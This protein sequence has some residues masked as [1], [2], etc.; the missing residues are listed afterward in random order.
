MMAA[1]ACWEV[2]VIVNVFIVVCDRCV[3]RTKMARN[4]GHLISSSKG[5]L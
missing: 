4:A 1:A 2:I 3:D 5:L